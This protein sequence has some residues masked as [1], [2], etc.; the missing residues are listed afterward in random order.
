MKNTSLLHAGKT[1]QVLGL[2][3]TLGALP[4]M[5]GVTGC[6][7]GNRHH[8]STGEY[9]DDHALSSAVKEALANDPQYK[10]PDVKVMTFKGVVQLSGFANTKDE[11]RRAGEVARSVEGV[12][13]VENNMTVK[14]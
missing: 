5:L 14:E 9:V 1:L 4:L 2:A 8:Q 13:E 11:K 12:K 10:H 3:I 6:S 7:T